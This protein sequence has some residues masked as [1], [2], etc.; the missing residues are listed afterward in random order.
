MDYLFS[1]QKIGITECMRKLAI[2]IS[3]FN[4]RAENMGNV[5]LDPI[6]NVRYIIVHQVTE[7]IYQIKNDIPNRNDV[8]Y[9]K[10]FGKGVSRSR[11]IA[12]SLADDDEIILLSDDDVKFEV[13]YVLK[14]MGTYED[15]P[16]LDICVFKIK[17]LD[18]EQEYKNYSEFSKTIKN[19]EEL[20]PVP[21][22]IEMTFVKKSLS[23]YNI[24]FDE[25][26]GAGS[27]LIGGE[28]NLLL[29]ACLKQGLKMKYVPEYIVAHPYESTSTKYL[30]Y[31]KERS[32]YQGAHNY[33]AMGVEG[34]FRTLLSPV[35]NIQ[36]IKK[37]GS[38]LT[39]LWYS[40]QGYMYM[41]LTDLIKGSRTEI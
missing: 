33:M 3:T 19:V 16:D 30:K 18:G 12:C 10:I 37:E 4:E 31:G 7:Q 27:F 35:K 40:F 32:R 9:K 41:V 15:S 8:T 14:I 17:T 2:C 13:N 34:F 39:H 21:S 25:R 26:F 29:R 23:Q 38:P 22:I 1:R 6:E 24:K 28:E 20:N 5:L 36:M 11:N